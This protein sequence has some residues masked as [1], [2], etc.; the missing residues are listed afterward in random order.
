MSLPVTILLPSNPS[1][2]EWLLNGVL[3]LFRMFD[4]LS[5][6]ELALLIPA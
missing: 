1:N 4:T 6:R 3:K 5:R 2:L